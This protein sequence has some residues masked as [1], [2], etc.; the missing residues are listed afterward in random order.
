MSDASTSPRTKAQNISNARLHHKSPEDRRQEAVL[1]QKEYNGLTLQRKLA[2]AI[3][4]GTN[5][6]TKEIVRLSALFAKKVEVVVNPPT[7]AQRQ[8]D[9]TSREV[10]RAQNAVKHMSQTKKGN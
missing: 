2:R 6:E 10:M 3:E 8:A 9:R 7:K 1:R 5:D 4:R